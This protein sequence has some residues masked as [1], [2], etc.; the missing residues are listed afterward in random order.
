[1]DGNRPHR[2]PLILLVSAAVMLAA[3]LVLSAPDGS[4]QTAA[5]DPLQL[6]AKIPLGN[7]AGRIDH[8]AVDVGRR[9]LFVA[10][11]GNNT[12]GV[13][14]LE[15]RKVVHRITGLSEPQG[16]AY[17]ASNDSLYVANAG[18]GS[19]RI[20]RGADYAPAGRIDLGEDADNIRVDT[21]ANRLLVGY[22]NGAIAVIAL[23]GNGKAKA[24]ALK[25]HPE[26]FQLDPAASRIFVNV[27]AAR[28]IVVLDSATGEERANWPMKY[29][30]NFA[31]V[32]DHER[33][34]VLVVFRNP[35]KLVAFSKNTGATAGEADACGDADDLFLDSKRNRVYIACGAGFLDV[36]NAQDA[37]FPRLARIPTVSGARTALFVPEIDRLLLG[38]RARSGES[39][40]IWVYRAAP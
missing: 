22:G 2:M 4:A 21:A 26:S 25:A 35:A 30:A 32:L 14:D 7:V 34:R 33:P 29:G 36:L 9:R 8:M 16:V 15:V 3:V 20:F 6:E 23:P 38:V 37:A 24:V 12:V 17:V 18:D 19:V 40:A 10:E 13:V 1:M 5:S 28:S 27:P 31:M 11:L 39:A